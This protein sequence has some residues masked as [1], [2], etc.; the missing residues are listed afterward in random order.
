M[1]LGY[2]SEKLTSALNAMATSSKPI[3][4]RLK[5]AALSAHTIMPNG[6]EVDWPSEEL[7]GRW[8]EWWGAITAREGQG[9]E[10]SIEA[11]TSQLT[12]AEAE[13]LAEQLF[14]ITMAVE[15]EYHRSGQI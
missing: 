15:W 1:S 2:I 9:N 3:Q 11:T 12:D 4:V 6:P 7:A 5:Y 10:G 14:E 8:A 13:R